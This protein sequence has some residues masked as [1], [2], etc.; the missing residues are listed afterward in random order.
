[1]VLP[2]EWLVANGRIRVAAARADEMLV[3]AGILD[4]ASAWLESRGLER[5]PRPI[6]LTALEATLALGPTYLAWDGPT[7]VGTFSLYRTDARF[8]GERPAEPPGYARYLHK[9]AIRRSHPGLGRELVALAAR[10]AREGGAACLRLDCVA[11][12]P[13]IRAYYEAAG[14]EYRGQVSGPAFDVPYAL[15]EKPLG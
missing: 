7:A 10:L 2:Q 6:P 9:L 1:M 4:E 15:Y 14:F 5:W 3:A 13:A 8:W 12:N 11:G